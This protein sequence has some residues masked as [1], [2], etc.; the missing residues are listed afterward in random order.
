MLISAIQWCASVSINVP[1]YS[2]GR[3]GVA[4]AVVIDG[5][6]VVALPTVLAAKRA[7]TKTGYP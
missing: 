1:I 6:I 2:C 7:V 5:T 3:P 4:V